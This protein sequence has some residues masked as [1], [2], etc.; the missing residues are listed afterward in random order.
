MKFAVQAQF[1][2][3]VLRLSCD[4]ASA[5][6]LAPGTVRCIIHHEQSPQ[7]V[8]CRPKHCK[9]GEPGEAAGRSSQCPES[10]R[11]RTRWR[12]PEGGSNSDR[13]A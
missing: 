8:V 3:V 4:F 10:L 1:L 2:C 5:W 11:G 6:H 13:S 9:G 7:G 12:N